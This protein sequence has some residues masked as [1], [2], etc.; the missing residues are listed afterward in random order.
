MTT[1]HQPDQRAKNIQTFEDSYVHV[2]DDYK[3]RS[4]LNYVADHVEYEGNALR[5]QGLEDG[6]INVKI[7]A[8]AK[9]WIRYIYDELGIRHPLICK[10]VPVEASV[11]TIA[12]EGRIW[13]QLMAL[14]RRGGVRLKRKMPYNDKY[15]PWE[16]CVINMYYVILEYLIMKGLGK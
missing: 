16:N 2:S 8:Y 7:E 1:K 12:N 6:E 10:F 3:V 11:A 9:D 14:C 15:G 5:A 13:Q 4:I